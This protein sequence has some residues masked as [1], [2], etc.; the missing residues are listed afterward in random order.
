MQHIPS[1]PV[2]VAYCA[3]PG[4]LLLL[5]LPART[6]IRTHTDLVCLVGLLQFAAKLASEI[7]LVL[8]LLDLHRGT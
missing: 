8:G 2:A 6:A 1:Q 5:L 7:G 4:L 3:Q